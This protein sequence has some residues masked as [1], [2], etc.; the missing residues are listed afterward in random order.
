MRYNVVKNAS[1]IVHSSDYLVQN[2][3]SYKGK[4]NTLFNN[5]NPIFL[6]LGMGRG[7]FIIEMAKL[8]PNYN[9]IGLDLDLS[10]TA[11]AINNIGTKELNNLKMICG[12]AK[13][14]INIFGK[15]ID[16]IY[17]TFSEPWPKKQDAKR[18]FTDESYLKL[19]DRIFKKD[20]H[21]ILKTDNKILFQS[22]LESLSGYWYTFDKVSLD[23]HNDERNIENVMTDFEKEYLKYHRPIYYL[24]AS[25]K[26]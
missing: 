22:G 5:N 9:Y 14:I 20:K 18:R 15:E 16:T 1:K 17:L 11:S 8:H 19:Y 25:F 6:E 24:E 2:P 7:S 23:L 3:E 26:N 10:Q 13:D 4:W 12:D 21:I